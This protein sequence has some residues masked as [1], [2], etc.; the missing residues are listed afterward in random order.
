MHLADDRIARNAIGKFSGNLTGALSI[1]PEF[2][3]LFNALISPGHASSI[4]S[5]RG[6]SG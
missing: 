3:Q 4:H 2:A 5:W 6:S 1:E